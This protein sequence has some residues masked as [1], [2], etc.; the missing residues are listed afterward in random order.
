MEIKKPIFILGA[1]KSGT[2]LLRNLLSDHSSL[3]PIPF[4]SH[5]FELD[6]YWVDYEYRK[7]VPKR[8]YDFY[9]SAIELAFLNNRTQDRIGDSFLDGRLNEM[10]FKEFLKGVNEKKGKEKI[11]HYYSSIIKSVEGISFQEE[12]RIVEKSVENVEFATEITNFFPDAKFIHIVR[13]PYS[14]W[15][16]LRNYKKIGV[17]YPLIHRMVKNFSDSY[18]WLDKNKKNI[19]EYKVIKYEDLISNTEVAMKDL[20][21]FLELEFEPILLQPT[22]LGQP[23]GG[24]STTKKSFSGVSK[25]GIEGWKSAIQPTELYFIDK[26]MGNIINEYGYTLEPYRK[27]FWRK[28][29]GESLKRYLAN[30]VYKYFLDS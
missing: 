15:V 30:R 2:S 12:K 14:N 24:N 25:I 28:M 9:E 23:W 21:D 29:K 19:K 6:N 16:S 10:K 8:K 4:E 11:S 27:G 7:S 18:Y 3:M 1:H 22:F 5:F 26:S 17:G 13:N 20:C